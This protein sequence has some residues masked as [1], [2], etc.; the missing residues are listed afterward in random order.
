MGQFA[1]ELKSTS[2]APCKLGEGTAKNGSAFC[3][4]CA[5]GQHA[6]VSEKGVC[7][8]CLENT[9]SDVAGMKQCEMCLPGEMSPPGATICAAPA[10][11]TNLRPPSPPQ[12]EVVEGRI[13]AIRLKWTHEGGGEIKPDGFYVRIGSS[14]DFED[15]I[16]VATI[17]NGNSTSSVVEVE[18]GVALWLL[19]QTR[20]MQVSAYVAKDKSQSEWSTATEPWV[21]ADRCDNDEF[22]ATNHTITPNEWY[23]T[24]CPDGARWVLTSVFL[25]SLHIFLLFHVIVY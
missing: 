24:Q 14:R 12:I 21:L 3:I 22:L 4:G 11:N 1:H 5:R 16:T 8:N 7:R 13:D 18:P 25:C 2:C 17:R 9:Y 10:T 19:K 15:G 6:G 23:C 20:Y